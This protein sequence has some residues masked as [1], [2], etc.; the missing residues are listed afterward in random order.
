MPVTAAT[1]TSVS[2]RAGRLGP[3]YASLG[4]GQGDP[5][6]RRMTNAGS[7][8][9]EYNPGFHP[10][11]WSQGRYLRSERRPAGEVYPR[12]SRS[13][14]GA[15]N[16]FTRWCK[17]TPPRP[18]PCRRSSLDPPPLCCL[19]SDTPHGVPQLLVVVFVRPIQRKGSPAL[20][21]R[22]QSNR[23]TIPIEAEL[24]TH[25]EICDWL[26]W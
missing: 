23:F 26:P 16:R 10:W 14:V 22:G 1:A 20:S 5:R 12:I 3:A 18:P 7:S 24:H 19:S 13:G 8:Q 21:Q 6:W 17:P 2:G 25:E 4:G 9:T 15:M 11:H